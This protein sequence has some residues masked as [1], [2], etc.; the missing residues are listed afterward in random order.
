MTWSLVNATAEVNDFRL[1]LVQLNMCGVCV[2][3]VQRVLIG[4]CVVGPEYALTSPTFIRSR[5]IHPV[6]L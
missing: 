5:A 6:G 3:I 2:S 4:V 1:L